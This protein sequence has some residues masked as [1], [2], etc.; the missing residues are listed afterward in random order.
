MHRVQVSLGILI[1]LVVGILL[2]VVGLSQF[3]MPPGTSV[4]EGDF[5]WVA[6]WLALLIGVPF[7][8]VAGLIAASTRPWRSHQASTQEAGGWSGGTMQKT[9]IGALIGFFAGPLLVFLMVTAVMS[10]RPN[11]NAA[12]LGFLSSPYGT[13][14]GLAIGGVIGGVMGWRAKK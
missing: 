6:G 12:A 9:L 7:C 5:R 2:V 13:V 11:E 1:F 8:L 10:T 14:P 4:D 3:N